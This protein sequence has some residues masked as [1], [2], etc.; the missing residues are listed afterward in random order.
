VRKQN[1]EL[2][3]ADGSHRCWI[4]L[5][6]AER[7]EKNNQML[8]ISRRKEPQIKYRLRR[9]VEP[10]NSLRSQAALTASDAKLLITLRKNPE[11]HVAIERLE[12]LAGWNLIPAP[13]E[14][15]A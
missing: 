6:E 11:K 1:V 15:E 12:R 5:A 4:T 7:C 2:Q 13:R 8:R 14:S 10:S 9:V 3:N